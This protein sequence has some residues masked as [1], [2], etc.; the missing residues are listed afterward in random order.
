[1][2]ALKCNCCCGCQKPFTPEELAYYRRMDNLHD[3]TLCFDCQNEYEA[4]TDEKWKE[5]QSA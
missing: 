5:E 2:A 4:E 3:T 1:M